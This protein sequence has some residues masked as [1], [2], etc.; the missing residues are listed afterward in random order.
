MINL[1]LEHQSS[2]TCFP[3]E[4]IC[5]LY[6]LTS[7]VWHSQV[8]SPANFKLFLELLASYCGI[9]H[10]CPNQCTSFCRVSKNFDEQ[11]WYSELNIV[12]FIFHNTN[13]THFSLK[14]KFCFGSQQYILR[15]TPLYNK[16]I[17]Q[18]GFCPVKNVFSKKYC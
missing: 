10:R 15:Q 8:W 13:I 6:T 3:I 1:G 18:K 17:E 5:W 14:E 16:L 4:V 9:A 2:K 11:T 7:W 12:Y